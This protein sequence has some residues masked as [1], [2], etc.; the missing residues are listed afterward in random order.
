MYHIY[1]YTA[2]SN[3]ALAKNL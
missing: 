2:Q 1:I 3:R